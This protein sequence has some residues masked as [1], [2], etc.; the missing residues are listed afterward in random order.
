MKKILISS[1]SICLAVSMMT[2]CGS[3]AESTTTEAVTASEI[4]TTTAATTEATTTTTSEAVPESVWECSEER[5]KWGESNG[6]KFV[7]TMI[8]DGGFSNSATRNSDLTV[9]IRCYGDVNS[10][11][12]MVLFM[13]YEY[14]NHQASG[15][16]D[17]YDITITDES[18]KTFKKKGMLLSS[19]FVYGGTDYEK[20]YKEF[21]DLLLNNKILKVEM[22][23]RSSYGTPSEYWFKIDTSGFKEA[24]EEAY[25]S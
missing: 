21:V 9:Q 3:T 24:Y 22:D 10:E 16:G 6:V 15:N 11:K 19:G 7:Q 18:G 13:L 2:S 4:V 17:E 25:G 20:A 14:G 1:F 5:D 8:E 12:S 23:E